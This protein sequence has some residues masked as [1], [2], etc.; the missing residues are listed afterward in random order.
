MYRKTV[1]EVG[2]DPVF[3]VHELT[4]CNTEEPPV[5]WIPP[6]PSKTGLAVWLALAAADSKRNRAV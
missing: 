6:A 3:S 1:M 5:S 2:A 4:G